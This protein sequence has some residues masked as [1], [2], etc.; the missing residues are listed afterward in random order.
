MNK[1]LCKYDLKESEILSKHCTMK[2]GGKADF[3]FEPQTNK[4]L[5]SIIRDCKKNNVKFFILGNGSNVIFTDKGFRGVI[6]CTKKLNKIKIKDTKLCVDSGVN[7]YVL[8]NVLI[9]NSL[10]GMEW[11]YGIPGTIGGA[12]CMNAGAYGGEMK[13]VIE[14]VKIFDGEKVRYLTLSQMEMSYRNSIIKQKGYI[15]LN[16]YIKLK[17][18]EQKEIEKKCK[19]YLLKRKMTQP[20]EFFNSGSIF[21]TTNGIIAGKIIDNLGL[22]GVKINQAQISSLHANFIVNL[23]NATCEDITNLIQL[24]KTKVKEETNVELKEEVIIVGER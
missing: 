12:V 14:K 19:N 3:Y 11:S 4:E 23:G 21:K 16:V 5:L 15:V 17:K 13:D 24:I 18:G 2:V 9:K 20:L 8:H 6:I 22:K 7:L 1:L 10:K